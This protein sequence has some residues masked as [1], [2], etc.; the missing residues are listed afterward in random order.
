MSIKFARITYILNQIV[1]ISIQPLKIVGRGNKRQI[2][3]YA[4]F[5][6]IM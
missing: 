1:H 4:Q 6:S 2:S 3:A 5:D